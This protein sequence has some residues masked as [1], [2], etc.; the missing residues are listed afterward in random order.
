MANRESTLTVSLIDEISKP[1]LRV[2]EALKA[3]EIQVKSIAAAMGESGASDRLVGQLA[4]IGASA[5]DVRAVAAA[6]V[7]Y[8]HAAGLAANSADW[9]VEQA[10]A[11]RSW[12]T[13]TIQS[14]RN[15]LK[16]R[17]AESLAMRNLMRD[18]NAQ[19]ETD[20]AAQV[21]IVQEGQEKQALA[22]REGVK[23]QELAQRRQGEGRRR[24]AEHIGMAGIIAGPALMEGAKKSLEDGAEVLRAQVQMTKAGIPKTEI[25]AALAQA[26]DLAGKY[27]I[28]KIADILENYKEVRSVLGKPGDTPGLMDTVAATRASLMGVDKTGGLASGI[29]FAA[30]GAE[31]LGMT[32]DPEEFKK[33]MDSFV[34]AE[35]VMGST[36]TPEGIYEFAKYAKSAGAT[37]SDRFK[38]TTGFSLAQELG[39]ATTGTSIDQFV[40]QLVGGFQGS[41]HAAAKEFVHL[42][43]A[44]A[45]DFEETSTGEIK[46]FKA[47]HHLATAKLA[48][49]DPDKWVWDV[50]IPAMQKAGITDQSDQIAEV[51]RLFTSGRSADVVTKMIQQ[52][53]QY[54]QHA[55]QYGSAEGNAAATDR[56]DPFI[57]LGGLTTSLQN[58]SA[59]V[60]GPAMPLITSG[61]NKLADL[62]T[63]LAASYASLAKAYPI[64]AETLGVGLPAGAAVG[65]GV[66]LWNAFGGGFGLKSSAAALDVSAAELSAAAVALKGGAAAEVVGAAELAAGAGLGVG[67][68]LG[69]ALAGGAGYAITN[70]LPWDANSGGFFGNW[71]Y[72]GGGHEIRRPAGGIGS[73]AVS[74]K[75]NV[76][77]SALDG[78]VA[79]KAAL[80]G[81]VVVDI[82]ADTSDLERAMSLI[83]AIKQGASS[84]RGIGSDYVAALGGAGGMSPSLDSQIRGSFSFGGVGGE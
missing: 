38:F 3:A 14:V 79:K 83:N 10:R 26:I 64:A 24:F 49:T 80:S 29:Q 6:F 44:N 55:V 31:I 15:V 51:R 32:K 16:E 73:D 8:S 77:D 60:T 28:L 34:K 5:E 68:G 40:K 7:D 47:G 67:A 61:L 59:V 4:K 82:E 81:R 50:L 62:I 36:I 43:L 42:G 56:S 20:I 25:D 57:A 30:K 1:A 71:V 19:L 39:G 12:E 45:D 74:S 9:T 2:E 13:S 75:V 54:K 17:T 63:G 11:V 23:A 84:I 48:Q 69:A 46:G 72:G 76:N 41:Q 58:L 53:D 70:L 66:M 27:P 33:F 22:I 65:G 21:K 18:Q 52:Q 78:A 37:L 35:Q